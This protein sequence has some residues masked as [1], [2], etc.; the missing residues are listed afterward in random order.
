MKTERNILIA[1]I[2]NL[3]F[4]IFEIIGGFF[5]GSVAIISDAVHDIGDAMSIGIAFFLEKKS[6][7]QPDEKY[8]YGYARYS[9]IGSVI[10]T[11]ILLVGSL[12]VVYN[13][14]LKIINPTEIN[15]NGMIIFAVVG[16]AVNLGAAFVTREGDSINQKAVNLH[17]LED[18]LTWIIVLIGA[19]VMRFTDFYLLDP[20]MSIGVSV[21]IFIS[22]L[23]NLKEAVDLFL[24]KTPHDVDIHELEEHICEIEG[25]IGMH[26]IHIW[27]M[28]GQS[29]YATMHVVTNADAHEI[30][31]KIRTELREH[32]IDHVT[33]ELEAEGEHCHEEHC[34]VKSSS[35]GHHHHHHHHHHH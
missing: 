13:A 22:A 15:Y 25:V 9:V 1:F 21:F 7:K 20:L 16:V 3:S 14:V 30:K 32:G 31:E 34:H 6:K 29:N 26:H 27:S 12:I 4:S 10:T 17:M 33:L 24:E 18:V 28:D 2:L 8:T 23:K 5:T 19:I 35:G 11:L